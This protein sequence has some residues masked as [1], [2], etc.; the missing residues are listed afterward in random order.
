MKFGFIIT[1]V[2]ISGIFGHH[3]NDQ[4]KLEPTDQQIGTNE[5]NLLVQSQVVTY[6]DHY[7]Y[8]NNSSLQL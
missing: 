7:G 8:A 3:K 1:P 4:D 5:L 6:G 2:I